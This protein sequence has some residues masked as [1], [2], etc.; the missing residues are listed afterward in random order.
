MGS[1]SCYFILSHLLLL[2]FCFIFQFHYHSLGVSK[3]WTVCFWHLFLS[4]STVPSLCLLFHLNFSPSSRSQFSQRNYVP[5]SQSS[6]SSSSSP[7]PFSDGAD[8]TSL[9]P[10]FELYPFTFR[11]LSVCMFFLV[12]LS[13]CLSPPSRLSLGAFSSMLFPFSH[14]PFRE[15]IEFGRVW[16]CA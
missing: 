7:S 8:A 14:H 9:S 13:Y 4:V 1:V 6:P 10:I 16:V 2:L 15:C 12:L 3:V 5:S 11:L